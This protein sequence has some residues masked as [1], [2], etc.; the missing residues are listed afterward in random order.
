[1]PKICVATKKKYQMT[2]KYSLQLLFNIFCC[3]INNKPKKS[4]DRMS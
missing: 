3:E 1:M 2:K 4:H